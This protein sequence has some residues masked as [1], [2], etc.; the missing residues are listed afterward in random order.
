MS[1]VEP[2]AGLEAEG[3]RLWDA[4]IKVYVLTPSELAV[5][6]EACHT[7]DELDRLEAAV[8]EL[9]DFV[10]S[11]STGQPKPHPLLAEV[12][13]HRQLLQRLM[14]GLALPDQGQKVGLSAS[15]RHA[16]KAARARWANREAAS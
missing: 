1:D 6:A 14:E 11:G 8:R 2:P 5:L 15:A 10:V 3:M 13:A 9:S 4:V 12:R 7:A 16:A